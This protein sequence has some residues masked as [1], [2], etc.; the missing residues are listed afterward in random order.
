MAGAGWVN[1]LGVSPMILLK[2][3]GAVLMV[4]LLLLFIAALFCREIILD[5]WAQFRD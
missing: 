1:C 3:I 5:F 4:L 2:A